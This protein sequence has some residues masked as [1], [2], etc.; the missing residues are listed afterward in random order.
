[1]AHPYWPLFDL[2]VRTPRLTL[3]YI[4]DEMAVELVTLAKQGIHDPAQM[5]FGVAWTDEPS[6]Q[7]E[8]NALRFYWRM[9]AEARPESWNITLVALEGD[10]VV[11][12]TGPIAH[13]FPVLRSFE[14][15]SWLGRAYQGRGLGTEMRIAT[16]HLGFLGFDAVMASTRAYTDNMPSLGVTRKLGYQPNGIDPHERRGERAELERFRMSREHFLEHVARDDV[17]IEGDEPVRELLGIARV[18]S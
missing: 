10:V 16:L 6:P 11:G 1:M 4:D 9:R 14:T 5:P 18:S 7:M 3:R 2:V 8:H 12:S 15:G 17:E 13:D